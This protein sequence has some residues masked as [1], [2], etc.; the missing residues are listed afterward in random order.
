MY[1]CHWQIKITCQQN[2]MVLKSK[3][4]LHFEEGIQ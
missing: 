4:R 3:Y 1:V 2:M